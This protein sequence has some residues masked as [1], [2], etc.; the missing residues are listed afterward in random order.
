MNYLILEYYLH[1]FYNFIEL[2][3]IHRL[4]GVGGWS[5]VKVHE[6]ITRPVFATADG[7]CVASCTHQASVVSACDG[8]GFFFSHPSSKTSVLL[9]WCFRPSR[10]GWPRFHCISNVLAGGDGHDNRS[11]TLQ[12]TLRYR[13]DKI[14]RVI[15]YERNET[16]P[17]RGSSRASLF[18]VA[19]ER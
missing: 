17:A 2:N 7:G 19:R 11:W 12:S 9:C 3:G 8:R 16:C 6:P 14:E 18:T 15:T 1:M 4:R 13:H 10:G 5:Q